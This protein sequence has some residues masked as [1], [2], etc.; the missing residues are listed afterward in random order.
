MQ[1]NNLQHPFGKLQHDWPQTSMH[2]SKKSLK[3]FYTNAAGL[4]WRAV[5]PNRVSVLCLNRREEERTFA[6]WCRRR[7]RR[8]RGTV[9]VASIDNIILLIQLLHHSLRLASKSP[10]IQAFAGLITSARN[11]S[12]TS[13]WVR[14]AFKR[15]LQAIRFLRKDLRRGSKTYWQ[16]W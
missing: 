3:R 12:S 5:L 14:P 6:S 1:R 4:N 8:K 7:R 2:F 11:R 15:G 16:I 10:S 13:A 9:A